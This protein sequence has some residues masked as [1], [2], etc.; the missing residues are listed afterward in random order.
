VDPIVV[1]N[2]LIVI[3][4]GLEDTEWWSVYRLGTGTHLFD[5]YTPLKHVSISRET[6][7]LRYAGFEVP[8]DDAKDARLRGPN[9]VG[10]LTLA[11]GDKVIREALVTCD[12]AKRAQLLRSYADST[13]ELALTPNSI[14]V[15]MSQGFPGKPDPTT[16]TV[17]LGGGDMDLKAAQVPK[18]LHIAAWKR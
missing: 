4:M 15:T 1:S 17:P 8:P 18:G 7:T 16:I 9:V 3:S 6:R 14:S 13:R 5:T 2:E 11:S 12:D 10:V